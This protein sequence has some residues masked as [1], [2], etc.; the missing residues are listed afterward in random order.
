MHVMPYD[1]DDRNCIITKGKTSKTNYRFTAY[2]ALLAAASLCTLKMK[3]S[4]KR[5]LIL[6]EI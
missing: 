4:R 6:K 5:K 3:P 1:N 2:T